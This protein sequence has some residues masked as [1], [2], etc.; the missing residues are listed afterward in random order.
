MAAGYELFGSYTYIDA[1]DATGAQ[2][3][4]VPKHDLVAGLAAT[5]TQSLDAQILINHVADRA[6]E[7]GQT[8]GDY[9]VVNASLSYDLSDRAEAFI[10]FDNIFDED[11]QTIAGYGTAGRSVFVGV[12]ASF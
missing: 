2:L 5:I 3:R 6:D 9:T 1:E 10:R 7:S 12:R 11:Y 8:M 4:R